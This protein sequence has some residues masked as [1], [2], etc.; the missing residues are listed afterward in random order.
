ML[1]GGLRSPPMMIRVGTSAFRASIIRCFV[2]EY[3]S[4]RCLYQQNLFSIAYVYIIS[5]FYAHTATAIVGQSL[6]ESPC[7]VCSVCSLKREAGEPEWLLYS[8]HIS[9]HDDL[10]FFVTHLLFFSFQFLL[11]AS[12]YVMSRTRSGTASWDRTPRATR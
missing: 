12:V 11:S 3:L 8:L 10:P 2:L 5:M 1:V 6:F 7:L 9:C 4:L